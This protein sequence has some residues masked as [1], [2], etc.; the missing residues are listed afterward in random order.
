VSTCP[1]AG[2]IGETDYAAIVGRVVRGLTVDPGPLCEPLAAR[3]AALAAEERYE[4]AADVRDRLA[5]LTAAV[6]RQRR[7]D[8]LRR[9]GAVL[10]ELPGRGGA[11]LRSGRLVRSWRDDDGQG[12]LAPPDGDVDP[13]SPGSPL[14]R[15]LADELS[16]VAGWLEEQAGRV[17]LVHCDG[18]LASPLPRLPSYA[19]GRG[20]RRVADV[21]GTAAVPVS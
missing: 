15:E 16:C 18:E 10:V 19:P 2:Q 20:E 14:P 1:C 11:E 4:E 21:T 8:G 17:R 13:G 7:L 5:A 12:V 3:M 9:A 6:R